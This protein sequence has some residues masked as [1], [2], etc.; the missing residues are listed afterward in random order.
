MK[1]DLLRSAW[2][3]STFSE[4]RRMWTAGTE[5]DRDQHHKNK[6][7]RAAQHTH[8]NRATHTH[9]NTKNTHTARHPCDTDQIALIVIVPV[10]FVRFLCHLEAR[11]SGLRKHET[12]TI[13][14]TRESGERSHMVF[15]KRVCG[16]RNYISNPHARAHT[17]ALY[18]CP[19]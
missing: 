13:I 2:V 7:P 1:P 10:E 14:H 15:R 8:E 6:N 3:A 17:A 19:A 4:S 5:Q 18:I 11:Q 16:G 9:T 12:R